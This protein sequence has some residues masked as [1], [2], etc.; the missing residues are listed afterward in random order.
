MLEASDVDIRPLFEVEDYATW[1][2][3][4][5]SDMNERREKFATQLGAKN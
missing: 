4:L 3:T 5:G 1:D 2:E